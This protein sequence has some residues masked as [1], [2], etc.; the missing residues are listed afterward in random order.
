MT[1]HAGGDEPRTAS[2]Q[3]PLG[4]PVDERIIAR[5]TRRSFI[6]AAIA[7]A[8]GVGAWQWLRTRPP[9][10]GVPWPLRQNLDRN[11]RV[12]RQLF[13][14]NHRV[15]ERPFGSAPKRP[16]VNGDIGLAGVV[17][18]STYRLQLSGLAVEGG[19][20]SLTLDQVKAFEP[21]NVAMRLCCIEGWSI[22]VN[23]TGTRFRDFHE[24]YPSATGPAGAAQD[25][26]SMA[27]PDGGYFVGLDRASVLHP[28]TLLCYAIDGEPLTPDHGA[29]LRLVIPTKYGVKSIK[30]LGS[31]TYMTTR[32]TDFWASRGYDWYAGL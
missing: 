18:P 11:E 22:M 15:D 28:Q 2:P 14:D 21:V 12:G 1:D 17:D 30:R 29:P 3:V 10:D 8:G 25:Y 20:A 6:G 13:S 16:R 7:A 26:V 31:I 4:E 23:W 5:R 9:A 32:P 19:T 27:T 24:R